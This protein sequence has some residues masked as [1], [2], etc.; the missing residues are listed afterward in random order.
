M[1]HPKNAEITANTTNTQLV[2]KADSGRSIT[3]FE[4]ESLCI[5]LQSR[6]NNFINAEISG[7]NVQRH[8]VKKDFTKDTG[9]F[10]VE[11]SN[12]MTYFFQTCFKIPYSKVHIC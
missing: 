12:G 2:T 4:I 8:H 7:F 1:Y 11:N 6:P 5:V 3:Q 10:R 9:H